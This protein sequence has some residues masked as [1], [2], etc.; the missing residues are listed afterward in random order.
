M[1]SLA[2]GVPNNTKPAFDQLKAD[3]EADA[4]LVKPIIKKIE[5]QTKLIG[6]MATDSIA[7]S[8][9]GNFTTAEAGRI[10]VRIGTAL[11]AIDEAVNIIATELSK[12]TNGV[13][14]QTQRDALLGIWNPWVK[15]FKDLGDGAGKVLD[16]VGSQVLGIE[17]ATKGLGEALSFD[18]EKFRLAAALASTSERNFGVMRLNETRLEAFLGF[19]RRE[20]INPS[21]QE[22]LELVERDG[23]WWRADE[24]VFGLRIFT[25]IRPGLQNDP[26]LKKVMPGSTDPTTIKPTAVTL[27]SIDGLYLGDGE[28][29]ANERLVLP[30]QFNFPAVEIREVALGIVRNAA[31]EVT[32]LELTTV[33]AAK[34]GDA[35]GLQIGGAGVIIALDGPQTPAAM[36]P[37]AVSPRWPD[38]IGLRI[39]AGPI[40]GGGYIER[41]VRVYGT[42]P[43]KKELVEFGGVIQLEI[44]KVGVYAV[45]ILSPDPFS[46]ILVIGVRF[47]TAIELSF[48]FTF[49]G[50]G[51][52]LALNRRVDSGELIKGMQ[53]HFIDRVLFPDDPVAEAPKL[54]DQVAHVFPPLDGGFVVGPI[55]ELGWGSQA[56][57]VEAKLGLILALP[58]PKI[59]LLGSVRIRAPAKVAPLT[60][61]R[62]EVYG[63]I[64]ADRLLIM[65]TL[66][67][68]KIAGI[69][70]SGDLGLLI[71][72]GG[73]GAFALSVGGFNPRYKDAPAQLKDL[74][75]LTIDLS[76][77]AVVK[78]VIK[79]YFAV[80]AGAVMA[81][82]RGDLNA[83]VGVAS[84]HAWL[85]LDMIFYW[86]PRF[87]FA[88]DL[89]LGISIEVFGC[90]FASI[91]FTGSL[92][93][94]TPWKVGGK[95]TVDVWFLPTFHL[96]LGPYT[97]GDSP[98]QL[99]P[100]T[101]PL[102]I[103]QQALSDP[104]AW[105]AV[106]PADGDLLATL[107]RVEVEGLVAH[108]LAALEITQSRIPLE[109]HID[110]IGSAGVTANRVNLGLATT[111]AGPAGAVSTVTAPFA[112][113]QFLALNGEALLARS[114]FDDLPSGCRVGAATTPKSGTSTHGDVKWHTYFRDEDK[115]PVEASFNPRMFA[116]TL[117]AH[118]LVGRALA[119][120]DNPYLSRTEK[121]APKRGVS[122]LPNGAATVRQADD[123]RLVLADLGVLTASEAAR[124]AEA[125]NSSGEA[126]VAAVAVGVM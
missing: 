84:A 73:G 90:S 42:G 69:A 126:Q 71:Q 103:V 100:A 89:D 86:V 75:R 72:W 15:P 50:I 10:A 99:E 88:I 107:A 22:K 51:G 26:L 31:K 9:A 12:D 23:K 28:G 112:P 45:T 110:R 70:V 17:H 74:Q 123:G 55:V 19:A 35:V 64:S 11:L 3:I 68:S 91:T 4:D 2:D 117:V 61:F 8:K 98:P 76:P 37:W 54:L 44:L 47:P 67:D 16:S 5:S 43:D 121:S 120:R 85:Q 115:E 34:L 53:S 125:V 14:N 80:T 65:A 33:I 87:G 41:K 105:K 32:G 106:M 49:N 122:V 59:I 118:G 62:C 108:P 79:A 94:T 52:L 93:G 78:I 102:A 114:G 111:S 30:I 82:V 6:K 7:D 25:L 109:T 58:D 63:E 57:I 38:A 39:N 20:F 81:G 21:E 40:K 124:V 119:E 113:G 46:L 104:E 13:V 92:E 48:G 1:S 116:A 24:A 60:D 95:A 101:S 96:D 97:W 36:F 27:D 77:P 56:K 29:A 83:D 66:R 18:R